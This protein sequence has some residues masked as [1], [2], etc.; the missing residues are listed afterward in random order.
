MV[1]LKSHPPSSLIGLALEGRQLEGVV[2]QRSNGAVRAAQSFRA[3]LSLDPLADDPELVGHE[4]R[5]HLDAAG[6]RERRCTVCIPLQ[7]A[8]IL[9]SKLPELPEA[10][11]LSYLE[12]E[13]ER[14]FPYSPADICLS[15]SR[16]RG[17]NGDQHASLVAVPKGHVILLEKAL[18][19]AR[20]KPLSFS[21]GIA[22]LPGLNEKDSTGLLTLVVGET[23]VDLQ[24][25]TGG[26]V[27]ALRSLEGAIETEGNEKRLDAEAVARELRI[28][29]GQLPVPLRQTINAVRVFGPSELTAPL[30]RQIQPTARS[31]GLQVEPGVNPRIDGHE[32]QGANQFG[33]AGAMGL[34]AKCL[35]GTRPGFEF[36]PPKQSP[37]NQALARF[38]SRKILYAGATAGAVLV[39]VTGA[40]LV[41]QWQ[42]SRLESRWRAIEPRA[43]ELE[44]L[45][46]K[47]RKFRPWFDQSL[48]GLR[49]LRRLTE[50]FP[51]EGSVS[52]KTLQI[53]DLTE[54]TCA[55]QARDNQSLLRLLDQ[56]RAASQVADLKVQQV[57]GKT[58]LQF[59]L[60]FRWTEGSSH[61]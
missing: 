54:V 8:L 30:I 46:Q 41:Q 24:V 50:A 60:S 47:A 42:L 7:W 23:G 29:L 49:I 59:N 12:M 57:R 13:A 18:R 43:T 39:L 61:D 9:Q 58:P 25:S 34:A 55:G 1:F 48:G 6:I 22:A 4:I 14:G 52:A 17:A 5:N 15:I 37:L 16:C 51:E 28:T 33:I 36:L 10:D 21:L 53:K 20:L 31:L 38:S 44:A 32:F 40:L 11:L 26:G 27:A 56:L 45:Q 3:T 19:A 2:L 35:S